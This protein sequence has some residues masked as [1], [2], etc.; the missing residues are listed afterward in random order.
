MQNWP[1]CGGMI[2]C[3]K[4]TLYMKGLSNKVMHMRMYVCIYIYIFILKYITVYEKVNNYNRPTSF[5]LQ[6]L[7]GHCANNFKTLNFKLFLMNTVIKDSKKEWQYFIIK[8]FFLL[9]G[10]K[11]IKFILQIFFRCKNITLILLYLIVQSQF[12]ICAL[13]LSLFYY[14]LFFKCNIQKNSSFLVIYLVNVYL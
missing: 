9:F 2:R 14:M 8:S 13:I 7:Y 3:H 1:I 5:Y 4:S 6:I 11:T 10:K 12:W